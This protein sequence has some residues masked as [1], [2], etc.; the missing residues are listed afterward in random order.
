MI[1]VPPLVPLA[2]GPVYIVFLALAFGILVIALLGRRPG[3]EVNERADESERRGAASGPLLDEL[4]TS[5]EKKA[6]FLIRMGFNDLDW[7]ADEPT[8]GVTAF[9]V[10]NPM[11]LSGGEYLV[12][13]LKRATQPV[14]SVRVN[15]FRKAVKGEEGVLKGILI[16]SGAFTVE[17]WQVAE[18]A[19]LELVDGKHL[20]GL[21]KM[22]YPDRFPPDRI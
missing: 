7:I 10:K 18:S 5:V 16:T 1:L 21:L 20:V 4:E 22:F 12:H 17:G 9:R 13:F 15:A 14:D 11:P 2:F 19:P 3:A 8:P 6:E